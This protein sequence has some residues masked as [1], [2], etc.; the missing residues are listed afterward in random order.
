MYRLFISI[1]CL[2]LS[3]SLMSANPSLNYI[4]QYKSIAISEMQRTGI[5]A[6]IKMAQALLESGAGQSTLAKEANNHFGI[7]CGGSWSGKT[8][9]RKDDDYN[10]KGELIKSCFRKF[11]KPAESFIAHSEFLSTQK[12]YQD[13]FNLS[14]TDYKAWAHGLKK[15]GYATDKRYPEKLIQLIEK[16]SLYELDYIDDQSYVSASQPKVLERSHNSDKTEKRQAETS[17]RTSRSSKSRKKTNKG[18]SG[19][20]K[21]SRKSNKEFHVVKHGETIADIAAKYG[22]SEK[23]LRFRNRLPKNAEVLAG[24]EI[25]LSKKL[26]LFKRPAFVRVEDSQDIVNA[27]YLF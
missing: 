22:I 5:P 23:K 27:D 6:S 17:K 25:Q 8:F 20:N 15:A 3:I 10:S 24:E 1:V 9:Y 19:K 14:M 7:K 4:E 2:L 13:L 12:R 11:K 18:R 21:R 26:R 16:Y